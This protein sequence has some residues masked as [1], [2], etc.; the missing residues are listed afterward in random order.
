MGLDLGIFLTYAGA[1]IL[2]F[3]FG[4]LF[5]WPLKII[6]KLVL[7]SLIGG[8]AILVINALGAPFGIVI[9]LN[10]LNAV[11]TGILGLPG[12]ILLILLNI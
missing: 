12:A 3:I 11:I 5:L 2:V 9:P 8:A 6:L 1:V 4:R 10:A 7:N